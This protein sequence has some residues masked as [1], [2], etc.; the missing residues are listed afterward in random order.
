MPDAFIRGVALRSADIGLRQL[1]AGGFVSAEADSWRLTASG[2]ALAA[3][4]WRNQQLWDLYRLHG[5][6]HGLPA[7]QEDRQRPIATVLDPS[8]TATLERLLAEGRGA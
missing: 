4:N 8:A 7:V 3:E 6:E 1:R 2:V 5:H